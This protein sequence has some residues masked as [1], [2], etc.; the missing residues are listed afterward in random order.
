MDH[1]F[2]SATGMRG[3]ADGSAPYGHELDRDEQHRLSDQRRSPGWL[4]ISAILAVLT[5][6]L[7]FHYVVR[8][9]LRQSES[10]HKALAVHAQAS[11]RCNNLQGREVSSTCH[12]Q[13]SAEARKVALL[14][15]RA[16]P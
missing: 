15:P 7:V 4:L 14:Q 3:A 11:W 12:L 13:A 2:P 1:H 9:S 8:G 10:R 6:L 16:A 5:L